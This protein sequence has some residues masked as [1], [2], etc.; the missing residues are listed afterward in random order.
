MPRDDHVTS[1]RAVYDASAGPYVEF[2]GTELSPAMEGPVD[3]SLLLAFVERVLEAG[4]HLLLAFQAGDGEAVHRPDAHG[5][6]LPLTTYRH[7]V[8]GVTR[9]LDE[10]ASRCMPPPNAPLGHESA[11][12]AFVLARRR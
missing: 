9:R 2:V 8:Q 12:Q 1:A 10:A 6:N 4:G 5:T 3:R 11:A 7:S